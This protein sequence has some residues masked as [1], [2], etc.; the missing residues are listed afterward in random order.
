MFVQVT[1]VTET[2]WYVELN[3]P[4]ER[5]VRVGVRV[6][7]PVPGLRLARRSVTLPPGGVVLLS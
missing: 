4:L 1:R 7:L 2:A 5:E 6:S 3:N